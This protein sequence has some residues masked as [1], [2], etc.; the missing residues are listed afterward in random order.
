[1]SFSTDA[2]NFHPPSK[3]VEGGLKNTQFCPSV[4]L[5]IRPSVTSKYIMLIGHIDCV[6]TACQTFTYISLGVVKLML[7]IC[8]QVYLSSNIG[9]S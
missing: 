4:R 1:M 9:A 5:S 2:S 8:K 6:Q 3:K 7:L